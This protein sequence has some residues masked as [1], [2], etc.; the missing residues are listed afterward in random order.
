[1]IVIHI[2]ISIPLR[3][4]SD[5]S[6]ACSRPNASAY[7]AVIQPEYDLCRFTSSNCNA[8]MNSTTQIGGLTPLSGVR[9]SSKYTS[10]ISPR[11]PPA[12]LGARSSQRC[13]LC[14]VLS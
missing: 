14:K 4:T 7:L 11:I 9:R 6:F 1:M 10:D 2:F 5:A 12:S 3:G 13:A 8:G